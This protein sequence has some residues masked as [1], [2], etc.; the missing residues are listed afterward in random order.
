MKKIN[1]EKKEIDSEALK[2]AEQ[3]GD[4]SGGKVMKLHPLRRVSDY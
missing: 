4:L 1:L 2:I 3:L